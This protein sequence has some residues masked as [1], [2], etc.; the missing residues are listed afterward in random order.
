LYETLGT[1]RVLLIFVAGD[2]TV[3]DI[4][5]CLLLFLSTVL[6]RPSLSV[7]CWYGPLSASIRTTRTAS[8]LFVAGSDNFFP[9]RPLGLLLSPYLLLLASTRLLLALTRPLCLTLLDPLHWFALT[10][11]SISLEEPHSLSGYFSLEM[12]MK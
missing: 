12:M 1:A 10:S 5:I 2:H 3:I 9:G 6:V 11:H 8:L 7:F 4:S